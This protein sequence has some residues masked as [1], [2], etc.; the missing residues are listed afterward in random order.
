[1]NLLSNACKFTSDGLITV[2]AW[3]CTIDETRKLR[4]AEA[5][6]ISKIPPG[7]GDLPKV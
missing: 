6:V 1:M 3:V 7:V 5:Y 2:K 4:E